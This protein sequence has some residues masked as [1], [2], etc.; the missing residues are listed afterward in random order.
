M[1]SKTLEKKAREAANMRAW[2]AANKDPIE[3]M[4]QKR[5]MLL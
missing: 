5:G 1:T 2:R 4:Q 3:F